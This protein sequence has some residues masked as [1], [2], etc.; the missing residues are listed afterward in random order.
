MLTSDAP[1]EDMTFEKFFNE[2]IRQLSDNNYNFSL[3]T[4]RLTQWLKPQTSDDITIIIG[5][6]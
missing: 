5:K 1:F 4:S 3:T 2:T 6:V